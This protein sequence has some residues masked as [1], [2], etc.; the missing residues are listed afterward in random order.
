LAAS[1][2]LTASQ[3]TASVNST[4]M[5]STPSQATTPAPE[6]NP[7]AT[8][9]RTTSTSETRF[10]ISEVSTCPHRTAERAIGIDWN[11]SKI[12]LETSVKSR[13]AV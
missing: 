3:V 10:A 8:A 12:P 6:R 4:M 2:A 1:P 11:R 9:T 7:I 5:P 13:K